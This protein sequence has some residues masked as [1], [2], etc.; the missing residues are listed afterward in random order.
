[1]LGAGYRGHVMANESCDHCQPS[2]LLVLWQVV[3]DEMGPAPLP[4]PCFHGSASDVKVH[5]DSE[6]RPRTLH[7]LP[8]SQLMLLE[9]QQAS[10]I[11]RNFIEPFASQ[12]L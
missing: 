9:L 2:V 6:C 10:A 11:E 3:V 8:Q 7:T 12:L 5:A 4:L 1:M